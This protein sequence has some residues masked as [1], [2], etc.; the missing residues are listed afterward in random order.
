MNQR[1]F[2]RM[3]SVALLT[4]VPA[5]AWA[6]PPEETP[7]G[8]F[9][10][11]QQAALREHTKKK[12]NEKLDQKFDQI[13]DYAAIAEASLNEQWE[14]LKPEERSQFQC[15]LRILVVKSYRK[16]LDKTLDYTVTIQGIDAVGGD[17]LVKTSAGKKGQRDPVS[18]A[19]LLHNAAGGKYVIRD[20]VT[21][22]SSLVA[23]YRSQFKRLIK[24]K[25]FEELMH[26]M[27]KKAGDDAHQ[28]LAAPPAPS[29]KPTNGPGSP[30]APGKASAKLPGK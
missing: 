4:L 8:K 20:I 26:R 5:V 19:Y 7:Q 18:V 3:L 17:H 29:S 15:V 12:E 30:K 13:L 2:G 11:D 23:N 21:E 14:K 10:S 6:T 16:N 25:G 28:C 27:Q 9:V 22:G 1:F 24:E